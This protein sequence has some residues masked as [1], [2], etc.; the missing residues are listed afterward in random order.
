M[1]VEG[2]ETSVVDD[3]PVQ[4]DQVEAGGP[5]TVSFVDG[6]VHFVHIGVDAI[7]EGFFAISGNGAALFDGLR[8]VNIGGSFDFC[9]FHQPTDGAFAQPPAIDRMGFA[10][11]DVEELHPLVVLLVQVVKTDR[12]FDVGGSGETA[13]DQGNGFLASKIREVHRIL[14]MDVGQLEIRGQITYLWCPGIEFGLPG[15]GFCAIGDS[16][17]WSSFLRFQ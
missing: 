15:G 13:E 7:L 6:V 17:H 4:A 14:A 10:D 8:I 9:K 1:E 11:V 3:A 2:T 5:G 12:P 16:R